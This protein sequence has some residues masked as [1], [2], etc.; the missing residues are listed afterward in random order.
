MGLDGASAEN[1]EAVM[2]RRRLPNFEELLSGPGTRPLDSTYPYVTAPAW[3]TMFTGVNSGK[4]GIFEMFRL[5]EGHL[6]PSNA[7]SCPCPFIWDYASWAKMRVMVLGVPFFYPAPEVNGISVTGRFASG[8]SCHPRNLGV[9]YDLHGYEYEDLSEADFIE[10]MLVDGPSR[11]GARMIV[12]LEKRMKSSLDI[13]D[14]ERW[15]L[16]IVVDSLPDDLFHIAYDDNRLVDEMF[17]VLDTW[18][19]AIRKRLGDNDSLLVV[20]D[21]GFAHLD[22]VLFMNEWL[23]AKGYFEVHKTPM[24][25]LM[26]GLGF[27]WESPLTTGL[28][29]RAY[30]FLRRVPRMAPAIKKF[31]ERSTMVDRTGT[32]PNAKVVALNNSEG[33]AWLKV[34]A[35]DSKGKSLEDSL[36][37]D[38]KVLMDVGMLKNVFHSR[39]L[40]HGKLVDTAPGQ[41]LVEGVDGWIVDTGRLN[42]GRLSGKPSFSKKGSHRREGL[43]A[44]LGRSLPVTV[45]RVDIKDVAPSVLNLLRL[46]LPSHLDGIPVVGTEANGLGPWQLKIPESF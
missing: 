42:R 20:S 8:L 26:D 17:G 1:I 41:I 29:S 25:R 46:P 15:D 16:S 23:A 19:G 31:M 13:L 4:H 21:H 18:I 30:R 10:Q 44:L 37:R 40:F 35:D 9:E 24:A 34:L 33:V 14:S 39:E 38:L 2:H 3:T 7:R 27:G 11:I 22:R 28:G 45:A 6:V 43:F 5:L 12:D 32:S 36:F